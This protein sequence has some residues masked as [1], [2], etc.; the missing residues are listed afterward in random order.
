LSDSILVSCS[1]SSQSS[2]NCIAS[3]SGLRIA[4]S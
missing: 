4:F 2:S 1:W 3:R